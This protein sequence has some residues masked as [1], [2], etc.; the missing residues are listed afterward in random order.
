MP[1][2]GKSLSLAERALFMKTIYRS[3]IL[4]SL[5]WVPLLAE[6]QNTNAL[7]INTSSNGSPNATGTVEYCIPANFNDWPITIMDGTN[8]SVEITQSDCRP[9]PCCIP[10]P[11]NIPPNS[12][13][14][15]TTTNCFTNWAWP[16]ILNANLHSGDNGVL[17]VTLLPYPA[18]PPVL[19][20]TNG[21]QTITLANGISE[22]TWE[23]IYTDVNDLTNSRSDWHLLP[24]S[25]T[26]IPTPAANVYIS[27]PDPRISN[28]IYQAVWVTCPGE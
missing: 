27:D 6:A 8:G 14:P 17:Q 2:N 12:S 16:P 20:I 22:Y 10:I 9:A 21:S 1:H 3:L 7:L 28:R 23:I 15:Y 24:N 4:I 25:L 19:I 18:I 26:V 5:L 13:L 11:F